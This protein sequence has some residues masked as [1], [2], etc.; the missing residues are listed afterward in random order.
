MIF[1]KDAYGELTP[2]DKMQIGVAL[3]DS[4]FSNYIKVKDVVAIMAKSYP[5]FDTGDFLRQCESYQLPTDQYIREFSTGMKAKLRVLIALSHKAK[6]LILDE[7]TAGLDVGA[8][9]DIL[10]LLRDYMA[11]DENRSILITSHIATDLEGLCDDI[12][13]IDK[14]RIQLHDT[15]DNIM[16]NYGILKVDDDTYEKL[17]KEYIIKSRSENFGKS[18]ITA[19]K[20][21]YEENYPGIVIEKGNVDDLILIMAGGR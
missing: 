16:E 11:E 15:I 5:E 3:S 8:R 7:P 17:D 12:Y 19:H 14:G 1:G 6:L 13:L 2:E 4:G 10:D 18:C 21:F 9:R 20:Q